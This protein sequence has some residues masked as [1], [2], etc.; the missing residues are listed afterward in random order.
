MGKKTFTIELNDIKEEGWGELI[1]EL[2]LSNEKADKFI[3]YG[4]FASI[5]IEVDEDMNIVG[6]KILH[7]NQPHRA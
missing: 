1:Y 3:E 6:G 4:E 5:E 7:V 2:G